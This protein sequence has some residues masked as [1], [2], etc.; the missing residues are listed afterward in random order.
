MDRTLNASRKLDVL[1]FFAI[2]LVV[3]AHSYNLKSA[4]A[5]PPSAPYRPF[6]A[7]IENMGSPRGFGA[8]TMPVFF[9]ISGYLFFAKMN[10]ADRGP[11]FLY[12]ARKRVR[13]LLIPYLIWTS[14]SAA[15]FLLRDQIALRTS[16]PLQ[17][18]ASGQRPLLVSVIDSIVFHPIPYQLWFLR[19]LMIFTVLAYPIYV[20]I[21]KLRALALFPLAVLWVAGIELYVFESQ[22]ILFFCL[23]AF[24]AL[25]WTRGSPT[26][27]PSQAALLLAVWV[28]LM[29]LNACLFTFLGQWGPPLLDKVSAVAGLAALW[30]GYETILKAAEPWILPLASFTFLLFAA[31]EPLLTVVKNRVL[32]G[33]ADASG[34][35]HLAA[36]L[37]LP[38][39][40]IALLLALGAAG[41]RLFPRA[42][43]I[44]TGGR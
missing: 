16:L 36:Y 12:Q 26:P 28:G 11:W 10:R 32:G 5:I 9:S 4:S 25:E 18:H 21:S 1:R 29:L 17:E 23:G 15:V 42:Y 39:L 7:L 44:A 13:T 19:D 14:L 24:I 43:A 22:G 8:V 31:H 35:V 37:G 27:R 34:L 30:F 40:I 3:Y 33:A 38:A 41:R 20:A 6:T 2:I